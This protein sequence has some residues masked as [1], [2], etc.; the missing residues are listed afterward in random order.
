MASSCV[1]VCSSRSLGATLMEC[2]CH[3]TLAIHSLN[4]ETVA[5]YAVNAKQR[6]TA[7]NPLNIVGLTL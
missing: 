4:L 1:E 6:S 2:H 3:V 7:E 5:R